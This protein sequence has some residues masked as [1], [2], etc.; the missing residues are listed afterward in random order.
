VGPFMEVSFMDVSFMEAVVEV[1]VWVRCVCVCMYTC[2]CE[3]FGMCVFERLGVA[4][5]IFCSCIIV[6]A[7]VYVYIHTQRHISQV[8]VC[9][10]THRQVVAGMCV[11]VYYSMCTSR[12]DSSDGHDISEWG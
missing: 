7:Y 1:S 3:C 8:C 10:H 9:A 12:C 5:D 6:S 4:V 11:C 2:V